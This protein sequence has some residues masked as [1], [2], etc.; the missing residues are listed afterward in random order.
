MASEPSSATIASE[1]STSTSEIQTNT[2]EPSQ[3]EVLALNYLRNQEIS[4]IPS[5]IPKLNPCS[6]CQ[7]VILK[8]RFQSFVVLGCEHLF[9]RQ[10][11]ENYIMQAE[12]DPFT[13]TCPSCN[14]IIELTREEAVLASGKYHLQKKQTDTGQ[15]DEDLMASLGLVEGGSRAGQGSQ[16]KQVTMQDQATSPIMIEDEDDDDNRSNSVDNRTPENQ[17]NSNEEIRA[18]NTQDNLENQSNV[19]SGD[20]TNVQESE[21]QSRR[22]SSRRRTSPRITREQEKFQALLQELSTPAK[23]EKAE[24]V[25]EEEDADGSVSQSLARLYQKATRAGLRVTKANQDEILCWYKYAEGFENRVR[26]I[27]SQDSSATD[28]TARSRVYREVT[29]HLPGITEANLR[30]KTQK[31]R[32][33]YKV[34]VR[35]GTNK[36]KRVKSFSA[37]AI[38]SLSSTQIQSII[39]RFS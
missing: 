37:D 38:S 34:F 28:P 12:T 36:I 17:A 19:N 30:K 39:D 20:D 15:G 13:L 9:H 33:I 32:N 8:F 16:S 14:V 6:I 3:L 5:R 2:P 27:R 1:P 31:A 22:N 23:G 35:I 7:R 25:D 10:C 11:L 18:T 4:T 29:Q 21:S 24:N 26:E